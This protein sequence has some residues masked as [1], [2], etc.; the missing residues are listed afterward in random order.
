MF[1]HLVEQG[2]GALRL[3]TVAQ[4]V[5]VR[6]EIADAFRAAFLTIACF[7]MTGMLFAWWLPVRRI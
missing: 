6:A 7:T 4:Q 2:P 5:T 1:A 3:L